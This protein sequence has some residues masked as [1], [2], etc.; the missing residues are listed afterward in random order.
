MGQHSR[1]LLQALLISLGLHAILLFQPEEKSGA[2][3]LERSSGQARLDT[4]LQAGKARISTMDAPGEESRLLTDASPETKPV[5]KPQE[6]LPASAAV[7]SPFSPPAALTPA[8]PERPPSSPVANLNASGLPGQGADVANVNEDTQAGL[9]RYRIALAR[10]ARQFRDYPQTA[11]EAGNGGVV[12]LRLAAAGGGRI[13]VVSLEESSGHADLDT[14]ALSMLRRAV[15]RV[16]ISVG[17]LEESFQMV[18]PVEFDP[19]AEKRRADDRP[20]P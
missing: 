19:A 15:G 2:G 1:I 9:R 3:R 16:G 12:S 20:S 6:I 7:S 17:L 13:P 18:I 14:A 4:R 10:A 5:T 11:R 8:M